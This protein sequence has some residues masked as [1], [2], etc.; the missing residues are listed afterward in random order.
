MSREHLA[1]YLNDHL[2]GSFIAVEILEHLES[3]ATDLIQDL[4]ALKAEIEADRR[5]LKEL[6]DRL[7]I[8][9]S[10]VRKVTS[11]I[12]EQ[13]TEAKFEADDES[14]GTLRRLERLEALALGIDGK[15]ALWQALKA[16]AELA[17][18]LRQMDY[19]QLVQR[20]QQ[21]RSRVEMLRVQAARV[22]LPPLS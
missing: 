11:W 19:E 16:A 10:R 1:T 22:A 15:S 13:V 2:A 5:Q 17:P 6:L 9:E 14:R 4:G 8:S 21:Q 7:G 20:A 18:E 12:T 3:E